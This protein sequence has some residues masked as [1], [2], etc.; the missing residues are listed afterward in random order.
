MTTDKEGKGAP[1][2]G[3]EKQILEAFSVSDDFENRLSELVPSGTPELPGPQAPKQELVFQQPFSEEHIDRLLDVSKGG[4][5]PSPS[6]ARRPAARTF[7]ETDLEEA[8]Y[9]FYSKRLQEKE[10]EYPD[11]PAGNALKRSANVLLYLLQEFQLVL[12]DDK[13]DKI[14]RRMKRVLE[15]PAEADETPGV[16]R[17]RQPFRGRRLKEKV[18]ALYASHMR[19]YALQLAEVRQI[20]AMSEAQKEQMAE[21]ERQARAEQKRLEKERRRNQ[22]VSTISEEK[23]R[24]MEEEFDALIAMTAK[25]YGIESEKLMRI[26]YEDPQSQ[27]GETAPQGAAAVKPKAQRG[28]HS[29]MPK[30]VSPVM[31]SPEAKLKPEDIIRRNNERRRLRG[32]REDKP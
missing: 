13:R 27:F 7:S 2:K 4:Q 32:L 6:T 28:R 16:R 5:A 8:Q 24:Q 15:I 19:T 10:E 3:P 9:E 14:I 30:T 31:P 29:R 22:A 26:G 25:N 1:S 17:P 21:A 18:E 12:E 23:L 11:Y 20:E